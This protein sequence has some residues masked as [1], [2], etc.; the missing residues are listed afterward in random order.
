MTTIISSN[1]MSGAFSSGIPPQ[2]D[3]GR[4]GQNSLASLI[5]HL[6]PAI[7]QQLEKPLSVLSCYTCPVTVGQALKEID[8]ITGDNALGDFLKQ[9]GSGV[10]SIAYA[11]NNNGNLTN[12]AVDERPGLGTASNAEDISG[13]A[14]IG[15]AP[16]QIRLPSSLE[17]VIVAEWRKSNP[18]NTSLEHGGTIVSDASGNLSA[19]N[20]GGL[21]STSG[22]FTI[23][24][25]I[26]DSS[27]YTL[28]GSFHTHPYGRNSYSGVSFSAGD[29]GN[30]VNATNQTLKIVKSGNREFALVRTS[31]TLNSVNVAQLT[32][33]YNA[34]VS[35]LV[36]NGRTFQQATRI[37]AQEAATSVGLAYY[38][39]SNGILNRAN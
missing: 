18:G 22:T 38:Q 5:A 3:V 17:R 1:P 31:T 28:V 20:L 13:V 21:G 36:G 19:Q 12:M 27:R 11:H 35:E 34:L 26:R 24:T 9:A 25:T 8:Q 29:I 33:Q 39:G 7:Q 2:S 6:D 32:A 10:N 23:D 15:T 14:S 30:L 16:S 4:F 37:A